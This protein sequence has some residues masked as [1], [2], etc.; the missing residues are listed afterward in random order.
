MWQ[1][2]QWHDDMRGPAGGPD[3]GRPEGNGNGRS[4]GGP[5]DQAGDAD[6]L[7]EEFPLG[8]GTAETEALVTCPYCG[9]PNEIELDP[10]SGARQEYVEDCRVCCRPWRVLVRYG[11]DGSADVTLE[12]EDGA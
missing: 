6:R 2:H 12:P 9:Q 1:D 3:P 11:P 7:E 10:G 8:N 4:P 5:A